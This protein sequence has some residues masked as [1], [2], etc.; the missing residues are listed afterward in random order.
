MNVKTEELLIVT[1]AI[2]IFVAVSLTI[3]PSIIGYTIYQPDFN[4][5]D[6]IIDDNGIQLKQHSYTTNW[7][8][9]ETIYYNLIFAEENEQDKLVKLIQ[10]DSNVLDLEKNRLLKIKFNDNLENGD[11][12]NLYLKGN[13]DNVINICSFN[14]QSS[15][16]N[17]SIYGTLNYPGIEGN[18]QVTLSLAEPTNELAIDPVDNLQKINY[19]NASH[20]EI[21]EYSSTTYYYNSDSIETETIQPENLSNWDIFTADYIL[22][23]QTVQFYYKTN[24]DYIA[25]IP[26]YN[27]SSINASSLTFKLVLTSDNITAPVVR[28]ISITYLEIT[29]QVCTENWTCSDW[30][31]CIDNSQTRVCTD[32]NNCGTLEFKPLEM[33]NCTVEQTEIETTSAPSGQAPSSSRYRSEISV[34][35][36]APKIETKTVSQK[37]EVQATPEKVENAPKD[38]TSEVEIIEE[39]KESNISK[40]TMNS[41]L[42]CC[43]CLLCFLM[44]RRINL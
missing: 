27:F 6:N 44:Y 1:L 35:T 43:I 20:L 25:F 11:I 3:N 8:T 14:A 9:E 10:I 7:T 34:P 40:I 21:T 2:V 30:S 32:S 39:N 29:P 31:E 22:N 24:E 18:Y 17:E 12:L 15:C 37:V 36:A 38:I 42:V 23:N 16:E 41:L 13:N 4:Y 33:Q 5:N 19:I 28:N 26:P